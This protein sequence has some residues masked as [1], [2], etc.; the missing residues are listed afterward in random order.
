M[1][2]TRNKYTCP[3]CG[4]DF[5]VNEYKASVCFQCTNPE[6]WAEVF[7]FGDKKQA[8][9]NVMRRE[10]HENQEGHV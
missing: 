1:A 10:T 9:Q 6:C 7:F 2:K 8:F 5:C 4:A 3:F